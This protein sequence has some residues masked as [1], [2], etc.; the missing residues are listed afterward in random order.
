M[1]LGLLA[2]IATSRT[3]SVLAGGTPV[4]LDHALVQGFHLAFLVAAGVAVAGA[5]VA[6]LTIAPAVGRT[7]PVPEPVPPAMRPAGARRVVMRA[8]APDNVLAACASC[9]PVA[10]HG[11]VPEAE[12]VP[13]GDT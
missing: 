7:V 9:S 5:I 3:N 6:L 8:T 2:T 10:R 1:G 11:L 12:T 4:S 13:A